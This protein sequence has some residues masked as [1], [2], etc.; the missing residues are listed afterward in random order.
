M[1]P[2]IA[3]GANVALEAI[4]CCTAPGSLQLEV[5]GSYDTPSHLKTL[6]KQLC[7]VRIQPPCLA[8]TV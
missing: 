1:L 7:T 3:P 5:A 2:P 4:A 8:A 6:K